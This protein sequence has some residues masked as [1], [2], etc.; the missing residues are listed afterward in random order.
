[1]K[2]RHRPQARIGPG[3]GGSG[4]F[5]QSPKD[6]LELKAPVESILGL[7]EIAM[8]V[9]VEIKRMVG[10]IDGRLEVAQYRVDG[11]KLW[12][13]GGRN[14]TAYN[15]TL[16]NV[17]ALGEYP[18]RLQAVRYDVRARADGLA[19]PAFDRFTGEWD[20]RQLH[21]DRMMAIVAGLHRHH[22]RHLVFRS[23]S[24][25]TA[26]MLSPKIRI[27]DFHA[28]F[29]NAPAFPLR[30]HLHQLVL[31][32]PRRRIAHPNVTHQ[33]QRRDIVL[34]LAEQVHRQKPAAQGQLGAGKDG[35]AGQRCLLATSTALI[36]RPPRTHHPAV[37]PT[38]AARAAKPGGPARFLKGR[39]ALLIGSELFHKLC[40][41]K[42]GLKL[43]TIH[44]HGVPPRREG[45]HLQLPA[46][47]PREPAEFHC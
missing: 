19:G 1:M 5:N 12:V 34:A 25:A 27:V 35:P 21:V 43:D 7:S 32:Q 17:C 18:K 38:L 16:V 37:A 4:G 33:L 3:A 11:A 30:H 22:K 28:P 20:A 14:P 13:S 44:R 8:R 36:V 2:L 47:S 39:V 24:A 15:M 6:G 42:P 26:R 23:A 40:Q 45:P 10:A 9:L 46:S 41:R 31:D 29:Q